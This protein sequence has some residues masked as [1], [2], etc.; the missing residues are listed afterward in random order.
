MSVYYNQS[1][2]SPDDGYISGFSIGLTHYITGGF[3]VFNIMINDVSVY[4]YYLHTYYGPTSIGY[5]I[6]T[7]ENKLAVSRGDRISCYVYS[8]GTY[9]DAA[10]EP[11]IQKIQL[12]LFTEF[13]SLSASSFPLPPS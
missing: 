10:I 1:F 6:F 9:S 2:V 12:D 7:N 8:N 13:D 5:Q 4:H 3:L 11:A